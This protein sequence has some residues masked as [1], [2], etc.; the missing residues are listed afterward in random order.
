MKISSTIGKLNGGYIQ[1]ENKKPNHELG[2][3]LDKK[4]WY[5]M[6]NVSDKPIN[7]IK[8][9]DN[10]LIYYRGTRK[11]AGWGISFED[12]ELAKDVYATIV[13]F[14]K[15]K[16]AFAYQQ[17]KI[18]VKKLI[19]PFQPVKKLTNKVMKEN[20]LER[21][22]VFTPFKQKIK[23]AYWSY[24]TSLSPFGVKE[25]LNMNADIFPYGNYSTSLIP[26]G[27][28]TVDEQWQWKKNTYY[29]LVIFYDK[30]LKPIGYTTAN[31]KANIF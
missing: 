1:F 14:D 11:K 17:Q 4:V 31:Y 7:Q 6:F 2:D 24:H 10:N 15:K 9:D 20:K 27:Y 8:K 26:T 13:Y 3:G 22:I 19:I 28:L 21:N 23:A 5:F 30:S 18:T 29:N 12:N 16:R 25:A